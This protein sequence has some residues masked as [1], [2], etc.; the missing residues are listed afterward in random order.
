MKTMCCLLVSGYYHSY[1]S[2][3][4]TTF[5]TMVMWSMPFFNV[6]YDFITFGIFDLLPEETYNVMRAYSTI[7][8]QRQGGFAFVGKSCAI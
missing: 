4:K 3:T 1:S 8:S 2:Q 7:L 6:S 5:G